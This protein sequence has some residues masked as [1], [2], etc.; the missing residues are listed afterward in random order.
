MTVPPK[1][2]GESGIIQSAFDLGKKIEQPA[3]KRVS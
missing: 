1:Y 3:F 2:D